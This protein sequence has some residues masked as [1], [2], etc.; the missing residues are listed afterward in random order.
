MKYLSLDLETTCVDPKKPENILM[1]SMVVEDTDNIRPLSDLPNF[2]CYFSQNEYTGSAF[3]LSMNGWI[4]EILAGKQPIHLPIYNM[5]NKAFE[6]DIESFLTTYFGEID[7]NHRVTLLPITLA[8]KNIMGF[9]FQFLPDWLKD[10]FSHRAIDPGSVFVDWNIGIDGLGKLKK[11]LGLGD[12]VAHDA[13][14]D[15]LDVIRVLRVKYT[16]KKENALH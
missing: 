6:H 11:K 14:Q 7:E 12:K 8:G 1:L 10:Y 3:A 15:A 16:T 5:K 2:T 4:L 9:D 13:Y